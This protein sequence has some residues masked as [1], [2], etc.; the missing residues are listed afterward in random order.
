M[1]KFK[2]ILYVI[3]GCISLI[4]GLI[5][6]IIPIL[7]TTPFLLLSSFCFF[8]GSEKLYEWF[9]NT[10][11]YKKKLEHFIKYRTM[12]L[13]QKIIILLT[14]DLMIGTSIIIVK[15]IYIRILLVGIILFKYYYFI[16]RINTYKEDKKSINENGL[17]I[18]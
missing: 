6:I 15:N 10:K 17:K 9:K 13:K 8:K 3:T 5:G 12:T 16:F 7:P 18:R 14:A 11:I 1:N 4:M 2:K